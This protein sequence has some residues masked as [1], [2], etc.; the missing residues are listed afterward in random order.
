MK[1]PY[2]W[3]NEWVSLPWTPAELGARLTMAGFEL[4]GVTAAAPAFSDVVVAEILSAEPH[5]QADKLR[6]C[7]VSRGAGEPLTIVCGASNARAGL[8][9]ALAIVGAKLPGDLN[10]KAARLRGV[11]SAGMLCSGKE[12]GLSENSEGILELPADAPVGRLLRDYLDLDDAVLDLNVT[13]NRGD[14]MSVLGIARE[15]AA[16]AGSTVTAPAVAAFTAGSAQRLAVKP[17]RSCRLPTLRRLRRARDRQ[18]RT[19]TGVAA[20]APAPRRPAFHQSGGRHHQLRDAR[21]RAADA[22]LRPRQAQRWPHR[23]SGA[24]RTSR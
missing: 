14:A 12:L 5:P 8:K 6:V 20:R 10:I 23:A 15:V 11:E 1:I 18:P 22:C 21:D 3:L 19:L 24:G 17:G 7:Q 2:G 16:L 9:S 13:P 4:E